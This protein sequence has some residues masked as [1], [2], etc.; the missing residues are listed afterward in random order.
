MLWEPRRWNWEVRGPGQRVCDIQ[1]CIEGWYIDC[2]KKAPDKEN[3]TCAPKPEC[4]L[5]NRMNTFDGK[6]GVEDC[7][8]MRSERLESDF[9]GLP[10]SC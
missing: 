9:L 5:V 8:E 3:N 2:G 4:I 1:Y 6:G 7:W 10:Q